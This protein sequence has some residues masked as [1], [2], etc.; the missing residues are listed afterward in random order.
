MRLVVSGYYGYGNAGDEAVLAGL[1]ELLAGAG[2]DRTEVTV[3]SGDPLNTTRTHGVRAASR[4]NPVRAVA[5][6]R[7]SDGLI[8]GGGGLLQDVSSVRP[9]SYYAG[10]MHLARALGRPYAVV[11]QGLGPLRRR[12]NRRI[13]RSALEHAVHVSLRD[14]RSI[15]LARRI[16]VRRPIDRAGDTALAALSATGDKA[17]RRGGHVLLAVRG[18]YPSDAVVGPLRR[19]V[20]ELVRDHRVVALP[21]HGAVDTDASTALVTGIAGASMA[22]PD[23]SLAEKLETISTSSVV[24]GVRLHALV[25]A[26]SAGVPAVAVSYDPKVD[27]FAE[28][29]GIPVIG[30]TSA[31]IDPDVLIGAVEQSLRLGEAFYGDRVTQ[32]RAEA[33]A[34]VRNALEAMGRP[35]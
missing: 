16:G 5:E 35:S 14:D 2:V 31:A 3:L 19:V 8:S 13:A 21:M 32:M 28:R 6:L 34:A 15:A 27:A 33:D 29:A 24:I 10:V 12:P 9:V 1:L 30:S 23:A 7:R 17:E 4:W 22:D 18:G 20:A 25:L 11:G 26:A